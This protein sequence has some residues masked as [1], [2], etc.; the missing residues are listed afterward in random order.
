[1]QVTEGVASFTGSEPPSEE[2]LAAYVTDI[3]L[4][5]NA[6][7]PALNLITISPDD[8]PVPETVPTVCQLSVETPDA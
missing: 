2:P 1:M 4:I 6:R 3:D 8:V 5:Y 7:E